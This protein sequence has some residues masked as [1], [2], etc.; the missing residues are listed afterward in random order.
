MHGSITNHRYGGDPLG[1]SW[2]PSPVGRSTVSP[3]CDAVAEASPEIFAAC[4]GW[5]GQ[6]TVMVGDSPRT[7]IVCADA[8]HARC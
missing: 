5:T 7:D 1:A 4:A 3:F 8:R 2:T 6:P